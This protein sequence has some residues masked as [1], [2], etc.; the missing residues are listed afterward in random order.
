MKHQFVIIGAGPAG[1]GAA[2][3]L[4]K[5][6]LNDFL[7]LEAQPF[8]GGLSSSFV[9]DRGFTWDIGG[10]VSFSEDAGYNA[11]LD[12]VIG[13]DNWVY[14]KRNAF[15]FLDG[16]F[17]PFPIQNH[18][19]ALSPGDQEKCVA[20][21]LERKGALAVSGAEDFETWIVK[22]LG[23][24][25][26]D[27]FM[28]PYN[29]KIWSYPLD[30]M[31]CSWVKNR[32]AVPDVQEV[33]QKKPL[34]P[35]F[36]AWG[37]NRLFR[38]PKEGGFG[39]LW[40]SIADTIGPEHIR[41]A[42]GVSE[43]RLRQKEL[44]LSSGESVAY[45]RLL[46]TAPLDLCVNM[47]GSDVPQDVRGAAQ[48]LKHTST[49]VVGLGLEGVPPE[50]WRDKTWVYSADPEVPFYRV[51]ILSNYSPAMTPD[52]NRFWSVMAEVSGSPDRA[53]DRDSVLQ[54]VVQA[55]RTLGIIGSEREICARWH[56]CAPYG[57]PVPTLTRDLAL[58]LIQRF[59]A[60]QDII[61]FGR[62]G[63]W[64]YEEGNMDACFNQGIRAAEQLVARS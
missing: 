36:Q 57:Y 46:S 60:A 23:R 4:K 47:C 7:V 35:N 16:A 49:H 50:A 53:K 32:V 42:S 34:P 26:A 3:E 6:G 51:T 64:R 9:D 14:H 29:R 28:L 59:L 48:E 43:I 38:Y 17:I 54:S 30:Q 44:L 33:L 12:N 39:R 41:L 11:L 2:F 25:L 20:G 62:F 56:Y 63:S 24:G 55:C 19:L 13:P 10:H 1:L 21:L 45:E 61:S 37:G 58:T 18:I 22:I 8:V 15:V 5:R 31:S 52:R 40:Q 27:L